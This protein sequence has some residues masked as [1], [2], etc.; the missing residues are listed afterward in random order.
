MA[1]ASTLSDAALL[2]VMRS[3]AGTQPSGRSYERSS[4][5]CF[6]RNWCASMEAGVIS[7]ISRRSSVRT[8]S[9]S[10][11]RR[12]TCSR[13]I[14]N[15]FWLSAHPGASLRRS[16]KLIVD[17]SLIKLPAKGI[18]LWLALEVGDHAKLITP[19]VTNNNI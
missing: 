11:P 14:L 8:A 6:I 1:T 18:V 19:D 5:G 15:F 16:W 4:A 10:T 2:M 12:S 3:S 17:R 13:T 9:N 7:S